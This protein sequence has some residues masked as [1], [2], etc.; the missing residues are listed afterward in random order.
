[1][2]CLSEKYQNGQHDHIESTK[3]ANAWAVARSCFSSSGRD[4]TS[5]F[6][7]AARPAAAPMICP[8]IE[9]MVSVS[10][11]HST[12]D[13]MARVTPRLASPEAAMM[14]ASGIRRRSR[15]LR[16]VDHTPSVGSSVPVS[17]RSTVDRGTRESG[18]LGCNDRGKVGIEC[19]G[20][21]WTPAWMAMTIANAPM[22]A[23]S[24]R[25][26]SRHTSRKVG[27]ICGNFGIEDKRKRCDA[28]GGTVSRRTLTLCAGESPV[29][30]HVQVTQ[31][32]NLLPPIPVMRPSRSQTENRSATSRGSTRRLAAIASHVA[33]VNCVSSESN[34]TS[35]GSYVTGPREP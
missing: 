26:G 23:S 24:F 30:A 14:A 17:A 7:I 21:R 5:S 19:L 29:S 20:L 15:W 6:G 2:R 31:S 34:H 9:A 28:H 11:P 22:Y 1:M 25:C 33:N 3:S 32:F 4:A 16:S 13:W 8:A 10:P 27:T 18:E 12:A 35:G